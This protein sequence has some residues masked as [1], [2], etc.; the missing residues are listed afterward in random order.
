M[1]DRNDISFSSS[2]DWLCANREKNVHNGRQEKKNNPKTKWMWSR[3]KDV[4]I[5]GGGGGVV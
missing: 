4:L 1:C 5:D 3:D 2:G